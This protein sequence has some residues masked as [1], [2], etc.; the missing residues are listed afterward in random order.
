MNGLNLKQKI[1]MKSYEKCEEQ[2]QDI[3]P[4]AVSTPTLQ[5][6]TF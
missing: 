4:H 6:H 5:P 1:Q 2:C 3:S